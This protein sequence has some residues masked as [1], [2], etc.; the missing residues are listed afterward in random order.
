MKRVI[1][2]FYIFTV[3]VFP[4]FSSFA[5]VQ[6]NAFERARHTMVTEQ[7]ERRGITDARLLEAL[8]TVPR[9]EFVPENLREWAYADTPLPIGYG[10]TI[11]Q[12][13][14]VALMTEKLALQGG[15]KVLE[16][17]TGSGYQAAILHALGCTVYTVEIIKRLAQLA[18]GKLKT[19]GYTVTV[20][21]G[22]GYFGWEEYAPFD[23]IIVTCSVDHIP[24]PLL[25]QLKV[26]GRMVLPVGPP[27][28]IQSLWLVKKTEE[29]IATE[30]LGA[31]QFVPLTRNVREE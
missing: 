4:G 19:L 24:P 16:V 17:G 2:F 13:Y 5:L 22:D 20:R 27:W 3:I 12:P 18:E 9:E 23:A 11:S 30:D 6:E 10:Q 1:I 14:I 15:E 29:G 8:R 26:G 28:S 21:W 31:V 25:A 7:I